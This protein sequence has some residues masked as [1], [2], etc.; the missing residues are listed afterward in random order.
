MIAFPNTNKKLCPAVP[1][2]PVFSDGN[3]RVFRCQTCPRPD[4]INPPLW[5]YES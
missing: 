3:T 1:A 5:S 2:S 4:K